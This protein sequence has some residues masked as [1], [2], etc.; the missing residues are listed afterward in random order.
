MMTGTIQILQYNLNRNQTTTESVLNHPDAQAFTVLA[1]QEPCHSDYTNLPPIHQSWTLIQ[2]P[3]NP[4]HAPRSAIY[5]N[6]ALT[7]SSAYR[8]IPIPIHDITAVELTTENTAVPMVIINIYNPRDQE[9]V[10]S[11]GQYL[12]RHLRP[13]RTRQLII[14]GDFNLHHP[15]WNPVSYVRHDELSDELLELMLDYGLRPLLPAGTITYPHGGTTIDLVWGNQEVED[16][17]M[18]CQVSGD[19][20]HGSDH[21]PIETVLNLSPQIQTNMRQRYNWA[22]TDWSELGSRLK[23]YLPETIE[24]NQATPD[25]LDKYAEDLTAAYQRAIDD[26][27][28]RKKICPFSKRWWNEN[29]TRLCREAKRCRKRFQSTRN[30]YHYKV[31]RDKFNE[32]GCEMKMAKRETWNNFVQNADAR[33]IWILKDYMDTVPTNNYIPIIG[34]ESSDEAK[35]TKFQEAFFPPPPPADTADIDANAAYPDPVLEDI[36]ISETQ[37]DNVIARVP[38]SKA[39]GP[40]E[41][42]NKVIKSTYAIAQRHLLA[43]AQAS[44]N[45]RH[46]P[47]A[48]K[49]SATVVIRK[50]GKPDYTKPEA[51]RPIALENT[52]GKIL[53]CA[54]AEN[55]SFIIEKHQLLPPEHFGGRPGRT[56]EDALLLLTERIQHAWKEREIYSAIFMDVA[57]A[58]NN[59]HH[60]RLLSNMRKRQI[61]G[62]IIEW[63]QS[64]L[65][66]RSTQLW[67]NDFRSPNIETPAGIPQGSPLSPTLYMIYNSELLEIPRKCEETTAQSLGFIDDIAYGIQGESDQQNVEKLTK[68][69]NLAEGWKQRHGAQF[70]TSKYVLIHFTRNHR[71]AADCPIILQGTTIEPSLT[72]RYLG[73]IF[74]KGLRFKEHVQHATK[75]GTK[76]ALAMGRIANAKWGTQYQYIRQLFVSVVAPRMDYAAIVWHRPAKYGQTHAPSQTKSLSTAQRTAMKAILGAFRTTPTVALE[77][78]TNLAPTH[79]RLR[80]KVLRTMTRMQTHPD[81]HPLAACI[82]RAASSKSKTFITTLEYLL[83]TYPQHT[84]ALETIQPFAYPPWWTPSH[85]IHLSESKDEA[86]CF[87]DS[88]PASDKTLRIYT[89]GSGINGHIGVAVHCPELN[90]TRQRYLGTEKEQNVY[91]AELTAIDIGIKMSVEAPMEFTETIIYADSQAAIKATCK[92]GKQSGQHI[93][94]RT[95]EN[96][97]N[98]KKQRRNHGISLVWIPGHH[99]IEG[100]EVADKAAKEAANQGGPTEG[101]PAPY[102]LK[103]ARYMT[104]DTYNKQEWE[105]MW[106]DNRKDGKHLKRITSKRFTAPPSKLYKKIQKRSHATKIATLRTGHCHLRQYLHRF[107]IEDSPLCECDNESVETVEHYMLHCKR[108]EQQRAELKSKVGIGGMRMEKLLGCTRLIEHT[109]KYIESTKR[110][111]P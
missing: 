60:E 110:L 64:F 55:L 104:I 22:K 43:L 1:L 81:T 37:L 72:G 24:P 66:G 27:T 53:E 45:L 32:Y 25:Q 103:S 35:A 33:T 16:T 73:V 39:P 84:M 62:V 108:Y 74:D 59:L 68:M 48:F 57:G 67:F 76:F 17:L 107:H 109:V 78:E 93:I 54:M 71:K 91:A 51:Y 10:T 102:A 26:T 92:P 6:K 90:E 65:T 85:I 8:Q 20:D 95:L 21:Y 19:N 4:P 87:H 15:L 61:P 3:D 105:Q 7:R 100:N 89:D 28:P 31:W 63:T 9:N 18:K 11:L 34:D 96:I 23:E 41:I 29:L 75:K 98:H 40:D 2:S 38:S 30:P 77:V 86:K 70:E 49:Q 101:D 69:L 46:F 88:N 12:R 99:G 82:Q 14:L 94:H 47:K 111:S 83:R 42:P 44:L 97:D 50:G 80:R 106:K 5:L 36:Q 58:F 13:E 79:L 56:T 52:L